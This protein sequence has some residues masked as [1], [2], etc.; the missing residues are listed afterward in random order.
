MYRESYFTKRISFLLFLNFLP[1]LTILHSQNYIAKADNSTT[2]CDY[3]PFLLEGGDERV[4]RDE[5]P[6][7]NLIAFTSPEEPELLASNPPN[8]DIKVELEKKNL[9]SNC[10]EV[11]DF[12]NTRSY[13][14]QNGTTNWTSNWI[15]TGDNGS[16]FSG[17][18]L[19]TSSGT[20]QF[21]D[22][23]RNG[24]YAT[25][26]ANLSGTDQAKLTFA[27]HANGS[28]LSA[29]DIFVIQASTN[30][31]TYTT[32]QTFDG[33]F[34]SVANYA[35]IDLTDYISA[36]TYI[37]IR[38]TN[39]FSGS[40][41][42]DID[43][44]TLTYCTLDCEESGPKIGGNLIDA[45]TSSSSDGEIDL[46]VYDGESPFTYA[47]NTGASTEDLMGLGVG[48]YFV[49]VTDD[50]NCTSVDTLTINPYSGLCAGSEYFTEGMA[51]VTCAVMTSTP[52]NQQYTIGAFDVT[53]ATYDNN[54]SVVTNKHHASWVFDVIG[55]VFGI[56]FD[57]YGTAYVTASSSYTNEVDFDTN[58]YVYE[59]GYGQ[60]GG[61]INDLDAAGTIYK[62]DACTGQASVFAQLPQQYTT[63]DYGPLQSGKYGSTSTRTTGPGLGNITF[64]PNKGG[65]LYVTNF[66]DGKIY[67]LDDSGTTL[68]SFDPFITD[69][70]ATGFAPLG[71]RLWAVEYNPIDNRLYYSVW[72][73][74]GGTYDD[75]P[76]TKIMSTVYSIELDTD[77]D[78]LPATN[79]LEH[80]GSGFRNIIAAWRS[81]L[82]HYDL[83]A[84]ISDI[85]F[86]RSG[87]M[88]ITQRNMGND[89][90]GWNHLSAVL[91]FE[92]NE[93]S[94]VMTNKILSGNHEYECYG[95]IDWGH[96]EN[97]LWLSAGELLG[98][99]GPHGLQG[100][101]ISDIP[102]HGQAMVSERIAYDP[103][104]TG[105]SD[106]DFKGIG[107][108]LEI[109]VGTYS[110]SACTLSDIGK[111]L[112]MCNDNSTNSDVSD[113]YITF[114]LNPIGTNL[115]STYS[116]TANNSGTVTLEAGGAATG[117]NYGSATA[118]RLQNG[119]ADGSTN[120]TIT[121]TDVTDGT[122]QTTTT[123]MQN[124]CSN[125][126]NPNCGG[127]TV[128]QN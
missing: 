94:W 42:F 103:A 3:E 87:I 76:S 90:V 17:E 74:Y 125:C 95:G 47:W 127:V 54:L 100:I 68:N 21:D 49:T 43:N 72:N 1:I 115:G 102:Y 45:S 41:W 57:N 126:P 71:E 70:G 31:S 106:Q 69:N 61:G 19:I 92:K 108:E 27:Y 22:D 13:A 62:L 35:E 6:R 105:S 16:A 24:V 30:G 4:K 8:L 112:E 18:V 46:T 65:L 89:V 44:L 34:A 85:S 23:A 40:D 20:F 118:F 29:S 25:R 99:E 66:E 109:F 119:S 48:D 58:E 28:G 120:F 82:A 81:D 14:N 67:R 83:S 73:D 50:N 2:Y 51:V 128:T 101:Q 52:S 113:D 93:D 96:D 26:R 12:F 5:Y 91:I 32:L 37:R 124:S 116:V 53:Q 97:S 110:S 56:T 11:A 107:G 79:Q 114:S 80:D 121:V 38:V 123:I 77:G 39:G 111:T 78:F 15:E 7:N 88:A 98:E 104:W 84:P 10:E 75:N 33:A 64:N 55:N 60:L 122:C 117:I 36:T 86:S 9:T 63:L 59:V